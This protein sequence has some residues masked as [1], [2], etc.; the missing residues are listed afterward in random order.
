MVTLTSDLDAAGI[1]DVRR[2]FR[3]NLVRKMRE[4]GF[5]GA[6]LARKA[7]ISKDAMSAYTT[8]RSMPND[9]NLNKLAKALG[10]KPEDLVPPNIVAEVST[11]M[12][13]RE[14]TK[15]GWKVLIIRAPL[16]QALALSLYS[17]V[18]EATQKA[19]TNDVS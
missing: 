4:A 15:P 13:L 12:E 5:K 19:E 1:S 16:P 7:K 2:I 3:D 10:C 14:H 17:Q 9:T 8:L 6:V 18:M 11:I